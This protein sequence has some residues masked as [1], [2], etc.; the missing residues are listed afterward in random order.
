M[1]DDDRDS[2]LLELG[3]DAPLQRSGQV[4]VSD[5]G[6]VDLADLGDE[7]AAFTVDDEAQVGVDRPGEAVVVA[8]TAKPTDCSSSRVEPNLGN[9][10]PT[11]S[12]TYCSNSFSAGG[13]FWNNWNSPGVESGRA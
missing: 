1:T 7:D 8:G 10:S 11:W 13:C 3:I 2:Y 12:R 6:D 4:A 5:A 9:D